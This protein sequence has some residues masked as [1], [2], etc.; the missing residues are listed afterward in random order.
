MISVPES[1]PALAGL[2]GETTDARDV[3]GS[4][5]PRKPNVHKLVEVGPKLVIL[6]VACRSRAVRASSRRHPVPVVLNPYERN[7]PHAR[8][9]QRDAGGARIQRILGELLH[10]CRRTLNHLTGGDLVGDALREN[11]DLGHS[12]G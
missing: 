7:G 2:K 4:A 1:W 3:E 9:R 11:A 10:R 5:S 12:G 6:L 8:I